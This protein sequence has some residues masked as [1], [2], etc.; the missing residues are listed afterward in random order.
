MLFNIKK[1]NTTGRP[2]IWKKKVMQSLNFTLLLLVFSLFNYS[3]VSNIK[4]TSIPI[5][6]TVFDNLLKK[7][8]AVDGAVNYKGF[9]EDKVEFEKY[10]T[11]LKN[12]HPNKRNWSKEEQLA[13]WINAYNAFTVKLIIDHYPVKSIK[14]IK[15]GVVFV[16]SVWDIKFINIEEQE[17]DLNNIEHG[18]IRKEFDEPRIHFAVNCASYSCPR[19]RNEA[20]TAEKLEAQLEDQTR[21][22]FNDTRKNQII[23]KDKIILSSILKW[24]STDFTEKGFLSRLFGGNGRSEKLIRFVNPYVDI[25]ISKNAEVE[26]M[27]YR[28]DL[29][30]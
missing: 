27:D 29:N 2:Y 17:Y 12:N 22:F 20:F 10:L 5:D 23:S 14:D 8:V 4:N 24:Y 9:I 26:F 6:H 13:Y 1:T 3:N 11:L 25:D 28:W 18:I 19:L 15:S 30:E 7:H 21:K 16:N